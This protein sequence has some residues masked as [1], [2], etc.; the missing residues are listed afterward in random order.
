MTN[1]LTGQ[2]DRPLFDKTGLKGKYDFRL[3]F[4]P[5]GQMGMMMGPAGGGMAGSASQP[6]SPT[7]GGGASSG[8]NSEPALQ[9]P[10]CF[11]CS[12]QF[13]VEGPEI[14]RDFCDRD[15]GGR[16]RTGVHPGRPASR[17]HEFREFLCVYCSTARNISSS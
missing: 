12:C 1:L 10:Q 5:E 7:D 13:S 2:L 9:V 16:R 11:T 6:G 8:P 3:E 14:A 17:V 4:A 15:R